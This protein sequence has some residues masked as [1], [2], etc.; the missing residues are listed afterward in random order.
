ME[1]MSGENM[2][3]IEKKFKIDLI[4][5]KYLKKPDDMQERIRLKQ[6]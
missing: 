6:T 5:W 1:I 2:P 3:T 4:V